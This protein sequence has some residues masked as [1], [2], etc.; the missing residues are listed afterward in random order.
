M[1]AIRVHEFGAPEVMRLEETPAPKPGA[2]ELRVQVKAAGVNPVDTYIRSGTYAIKP[3]LPYSPGSDA[4]GI[5]ETAGEGVTK[6]ASGARVYVHGTL[7]GAYAEFAL[8]KESQVW[9]L[10]ERVNFAEGAAVG[11]PY[12]TAYRA[13]FQRA[14]AA[15]GETVLIHGASGG[16]GVAATQLAR[17]AGMTVIGTAGSDR[18]RQLVKEQGAH[19][20][21]DHRQANY[22]DEIPA[23]TAGR[24]VDVI[25][26]MLANVNLDKDLNV[27]ARRGRLVIIGSRGKVEINPRSAMTREADVLGMVLFN[28]TDHQLN[29]IHSALVA[30]L[31]NGSLRPFVGQGIPLADAPRAHHA[32]MAPGAH[33]KI[34]LLP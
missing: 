33:G 22:L 13:L 11:V 21:L 3:S 12:A 6:V 19:H 14:H 29:S 30:G 1:Q 15:G 9:P 24:G 26:E 2:G 8:C 31:E 25:L 27:L 10:P 7:S 16:V 17:A 32:V 5:V 20:V 18:G 34:V 4:A 23:L 28:A